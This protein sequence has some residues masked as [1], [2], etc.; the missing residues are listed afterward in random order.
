MDAA[1]FVR[2]GENEELRYALR[3]AYVNAGVRNVWIIGDAPDW[4]A[5]PLIKGNEYPDKWRNVF[6]NVQIIAEH[7]DLPEYVDVWN[8]DFFAL[9]P[10]QVEM[11]HRGPLA[12]VIRAARQGTAWR[13]SLTIAWE[14][15]RAKGIEEPLSYELHRPLP[16]HRP[17]MEKVLAEAADVCP[18]NPPQWRALYGNLTNAGGRHALDGR[19]TRRRRKGR[20]P[21][22]STD[23]ESWKSTRS[24]LRHM[25]REPS[26]WEK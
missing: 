25:F 4:Y 11:A 22:L 16:I 6:R 14:Y 2:P 12:D 21:W 19:I 23:D 5:G 17:T 8:D 3:S 26:P 15:L 13:D 1:F 9:A 10:V 20:G 24:R 18:R 7:P